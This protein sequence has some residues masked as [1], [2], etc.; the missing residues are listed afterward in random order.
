[1]PGRALSLSIRRWIFRFLFVLNHTPNQIY[2]E[3]FENNENESIS[4][5]YLRRLC[6]RLTNDVRFRN[7][8]LMGPHQSSHGRPR[9]LEANQRRFILDVI[10]KTKLS[11]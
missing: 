6:I 7:E 5:K 8:Y 3:L 2:R 11:N 9:V 1:M 4:I 10:K